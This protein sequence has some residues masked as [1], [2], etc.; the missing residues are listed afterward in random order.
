MCFLLISCLVRFTFTLSGSLCWVSLFALTWKEKVWYTHTH[1]QIYVRRLESI[2][3]SALSSRSPV[4]QQ[5]HKRS[6]L[7]N[8]VHLVTEAN[9]CLWPPDSFGLWPHVLRTLSLPFSSLF[10]SFIISEQT[11]PFSNHC[12]TD[13]TG[14]RMIL[15]ST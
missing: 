5:G 11:K 1:T 10:F 4:W 6:N 8:A 2:K 12:P 13:R 15:L 14:G 9:C 7:L 3:V